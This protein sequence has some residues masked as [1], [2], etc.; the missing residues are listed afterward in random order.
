MIVSRSRPYRWSEEEVDLAEALAAQASIALENARLYDDG[1]KAYEDLQAAQTRIIQSE[2]MAV[3]GTFASGLAH[4]VRNPLNSMGLQLSLLERRIAP[5]AARGTREIIG[6]VRGEIDRLDAL[7]NDFLLLARTSRMSF[8]RA[9]L[10]ALAADVVGLLAPEAEAA[11]VGLEL[12]HRGEALPEILMDAE[13]MKQVVINLVRNAIEAMP[14]GGSVVVATHV[15]G[16]RA[17]LRVTDTGPGLP[18][19][20]DV[21]QLFVSTKPGGTGL[22]LSIA[23]QI[24]LD[25]GGDIQKESRPG[26]G[27][28]FTVCLPLTPPQAAGMVVE[29]RS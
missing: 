10:C 25:H 15:R 22:G 7:V 18:E 5:E 4:E 23:Q 11:G 20:L 6:I 16:D 14:D 21:F 26:R 19:D 13:K 9:D 27:T 28:E 1:R 3:M 24:V 29:E 17:C 12:R 8:R 2:K